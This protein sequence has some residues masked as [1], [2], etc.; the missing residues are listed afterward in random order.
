[1]ATTTM[2][3][4]HEM[5]KSH[6]NNVMQIMVFKLNDGVYYGTNVSKIKS[7][8]D[9]RK[10]QLIKNNIKN[11]KGI[12][13]LEGYIEYQKKIVPFL[14]IEKWLGLY[15]KNNEYR[16]TIVSEFNK[17]TISF[18]VFDVDN[19]YNISIEKLQ[20][21]HGNKELI[22]YSTLLEIDG[23]EET[24]LILD[25]E[26]LIEEVFGIDAILEEL[27]DIEVDS[28][29][30]VLVAED[31]NSARH[32]I[33]NIMKKTK[34]EYKIFEHGKAILDYIKDLDEKEIAN[35]G[36]IITDLE[37]PHIDGYQ[38]VK[39]IKDSKILNHIPVVVNSSMSNRGV[40]FKTEELGANA[41]V[42]KTDPINFVK[43]IQ[44]NI[45]K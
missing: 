10:Y 43:E 8:E 25:V 2:N 20:T 22:T 14:N 34:L 42:S 5:T 37:M 9:F 21:S 16:V 45:L 6:L 33:E 11:D 31:S 26:R 35:I 41:F 30:I 28:N 15:D 32:I 3:S 19:I 40:K 17:K 36:L 4:I 39:F 12:D 7:I 27:E 13:I 1:M 23:V 38:V 24:C 18:P 44:E 29:K